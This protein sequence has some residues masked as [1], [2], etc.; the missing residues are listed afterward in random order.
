[1]RCW[2]AMSLLLSF[3]GFALVACGP[4]PKREWPI[5]TNGGIYNDLD[6]YPTPGS[7]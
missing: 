5:W 1:M 4:A 2:I 6:L 7:K 3:V